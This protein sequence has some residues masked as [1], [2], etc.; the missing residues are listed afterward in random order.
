MLDPLSGTNQCEVRRGIV[1]LL[2]LAHDLLTLLDQ[3]YHSLARDELFG[4]AL[5]VDKGRLL[6]AVEWQALPTGT[7][8]GCNEKCFAANEEARAFPCSQ[9]LVRGHLSSTA[10]KEGKRVPKGINGATHLCS[11][12]LLSCVRVFAGRTIQGK[13]RGTIRS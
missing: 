6:I 11:A 2:A 10:D 7:G 1:L 4:P 5:N 9:L 3:A 13:K 12:I 8:N